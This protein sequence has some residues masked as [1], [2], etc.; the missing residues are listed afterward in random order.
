MCLLTQRGQW[1]VSGA[2]IRRGCLYGA[3][4]VRRKAFGPVH[5]ERLK[6][7]VCERRSS[8][9]DTEENKS[10]PADATTPQSMSSNEG[11]VFGSGESLRLQGQRHAQRG[12]PPHNSL[13]LRRIG[14]HAMRSI[15][16]TKLRTIYYC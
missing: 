10:S 16:C 11:L 4:M 6:R 12:Y 2:G 8:Q 1:E 15:P 14:A 7:D 9:D 5:E 3:N 13:R